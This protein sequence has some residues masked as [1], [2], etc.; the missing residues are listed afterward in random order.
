MGY[1]K[2]ITR[3]WLRMVLHG[4]YPDTIPGFPKTPDS[5]GRGTPNHQLLAHL[6][7]VTWAHKK[8]QRGNLERELNWAILF[9]ENQ[10]TEGF[11]S[12]GSTTE[13]LSPSHSQWWINGVVGLKWILRRG[14]PVATNLEL[15]MSHRLITLCGSWLRS[16]HALCRLFS[17]PRGI[18]APGARAWPIKSL[19][20]TSTP[21]YSYSYGRSTLRDELYSAIE[22]GKV[23]KVWDPEK[24]LDMAGMYFVNELFKL[25]DDLG[26]AK[27]SSGKD[28]PYLKWPIQY[29][30]VGNEFYGWL[31][32][33]KG[34]R[35]L[36]VQRFAGWIEGKEVYGVEDFDPGEQMSY[37]YRKGAV[38]RMIGEREKK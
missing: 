9:F 38:R 3:K 37:M 15:A 35:G 14:N 26:G 32:D 30:R 13:Q 10:K 23:R 20:A 4:E 17:T 33:I 29:E 16:H 6:A 8:G 22:R 25:G 5:P 7:R 31:P 27:Q 1:E 34:S 36:T 28:I 24:N 2:G 11:M 18:V 19:T 12:R 21:P